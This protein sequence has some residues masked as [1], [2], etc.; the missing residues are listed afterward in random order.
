MAERGQAKPPHDRPT[1]IDERPDENLD[2]Q[3]QVISLRGAEE[4]S[5]EERQCYEQAKSGHG[6][7]GEAHH[8]LPPNSPCG[9]M[10]IT[11]M[12]NR[13]AMAYPHSVAKHEPPMAMNS[14]MMK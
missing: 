1:G 12:K 9:R 14:L 10:K 7:A 13:K 2:Q 6:A 5:D 3:M 8:A 11:T 4:E